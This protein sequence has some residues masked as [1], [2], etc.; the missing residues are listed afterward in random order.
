MDIQALSTSMNNQA[1]A[2]AGVQGTLQVQQ[3]PQASADKQTI[4]DSGGQTGISDSVDISQQGRAKASASA[5]A[6]ASGGAQTATEI[7]TRRITG[8]TH[9]LQQLQGSD[10]PSDEKAGKLM[11]LRSQIQQL[12][13]Q[14]QH[15]GGGGS[16]AATA[17]KVSVV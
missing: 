10:Q 9:Q 4:A 1:A 5:P 17:L 16:A 2:A 6:Q 12:Q 7:L 13:S 11:A 8:L 3:A 14:R 15:S